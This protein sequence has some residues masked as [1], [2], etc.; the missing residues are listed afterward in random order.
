MDIYKK[1]LNV[2]LF[3]TIIG[4]IP[5]ILIVTW[6]TNWGNMHFSIVKMIIDVVIGMML[7]DVLFY[8][9]HRILH[10][11]MMYKKFHKLH[12]EFKNPVG[13]SSLYTTIVELYLGNIIPIYLPLILLSS[14]NITINL[15]I[16]LTTIN[17]VIFSHGGFE[18]LSDFHY[19]HHEKFNVNY[20][21]S[22]FMDR[23]FGTYEVVNR[24][25]KK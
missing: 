20:G 15:L 4:V 24:N 17:T 2:V 12:H 22:L 10:T 6:L 5:G 21:A 16:I 25:E 19:L 23:L 18:G 7:T 13:F 9:C 11:K 14:H 8:I 3:N 1:S